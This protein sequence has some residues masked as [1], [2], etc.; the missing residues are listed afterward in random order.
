VVDVD[1]C[2]HLGDVGH[3]EVHERRVDQLPVVV[4]G[5]PL[6]ERTPHPLR[7]AAE[8]LSLDDHRVDQRAAVVDDG[9]LQDPDLRGVGIGLDDD[10]V[11]A[12]GERR[13]LRGVEVAPLEPGL[14]VLGHRRLA[15]VAD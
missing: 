4:V 11:H 9:V 12:R 14:V 2:G 6:V 13:A 7:H 15:G 1:V 8:D 3:Q 5:H 10:R